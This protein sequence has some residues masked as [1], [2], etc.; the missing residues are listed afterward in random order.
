MP[1]TNRLFSADSHVNPLPTFW[2][3]YLRDRS[4]DTPPRV[5][6]TDEGDLI[7]LKWQR[8]KFTII[9]SLARKRPEKL[10]R[11]GGSR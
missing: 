7:V 3:D 6:E 10:Y 11:V 5:E 8:R 2:R 4:R 9:R 1:R